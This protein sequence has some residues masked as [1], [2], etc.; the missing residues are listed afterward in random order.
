MA[1]V[2]VSYATDDRQRVRS[3]VEAIERAGFSVWW[4]RRI[5]LGR[6]FD[7]EI[8]R[9]LDR[10]G[11]VLVVWSVD[12]VGSDWVKSEAQ[13]GLDRNVLVP[14]L[15]DDVKPPLAFRRIQTASLSSNF[16][17]EEFEPVLAELDECLRRTRAASSWKPVKLPTVG[18]VPR[19]DEKAIA[20]LPFQN[21]SNDPEQEF[22]TEG[23]SEDILNELA[24]NA[25]LTVRPRS[26]SF[27]FKGSDEDS[28]S[29]GRQ[30]RVSHVLEGSV[31]R[32]GAR[33]RVTAQL[34]D[35]YENRPIW[36][37]RY[38][39]EL[40]DVFLVQDTITTE[41][42]GALSVQLELQPARRELVDAEA[43]DTF[44]RGRYHFNRAG[45]GEAERWFAK[46]VELSPGNAEA[47]A[48]RA[49]VN[50]YLSANGVLPNIGPNRQLRRS[51]LQQSL[52]EDP[53]NA[54]ALA[55]RA[56]MD[57]HYVARDY[58]TA[59]DELVRLARLHPNNED[60][61]I[62]LTLVLAT[63]GKAEHVR[64]VTAHL[65]R[66]SPFSANAWLTRAFYGGL[67]FGP[68]QQAAVDLSEMERLGLAV[69]SV[70]KAEVALANGDRLNLV[71]DTFPGDWP[72]VLYAIQRATEAY[73]WG[74]YS[75]AAEA[76][77]PFSGGPGYVP[78]AQ[79]MRIALLERNLDLA[80]ASLRAAIEEAEQ[81]AISLIQGPVLWR[82]AHPEFYADPRYEQLLRDIKLDAD[83]VAAIRM[84][85]LSFL[86]Q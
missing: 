7:R 38:D 42:F 15:I 5:G 29:I 36:S 64:R 83:S 13:E 31:R 81:S 71:V 69:P 46:A 27:Q 60:V 54:T 12:S 74:N 34:I 79:Q 45:Y 6:S 14:L 39:R 58:Q 25:N 53:T 18:D 24:G 61:L 33:I 21:L 52:L 56:L 11:C 22:F 41:I 72:P 20:V 49:T 47:W 78:H 10:A 43:Y 9:E 2:F 4:D 63:L 59:M 16:T 66:L 40:N 65:I 30:L 8:E 44:L 28:Q 37:G 80:F 23:L 70:I 26:S 85:E 55:N 84:P 73:L 86:A 62:Y 75:E 76:V 50:A 57:T 19:A 48:M 1:D 32:S 3:I 51:Y 68:V 82:K 17:A 77:A 67:L 35:V